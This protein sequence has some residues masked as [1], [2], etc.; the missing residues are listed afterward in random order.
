MRV[1]LS[2]R[3]GG[4]VRDAFENKN[5][6]YPRLTLSSDDGMT[7]ARGS[8]ARYSRRLPECREKLKSRFEYPDHKSVLAFD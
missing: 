3:S 7:E 6:R 1:P 8:V 4:S 5:E 2:A